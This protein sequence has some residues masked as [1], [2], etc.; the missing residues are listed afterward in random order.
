MRL[1]KL[2]VLSIAAVTLSGCVQQSLQGNVYTRSEARQVQQLEYATVEQVTP[3]IIEGDK[4]NPVG[5]G[6]GAIVGGLAGSTIGGG[7]G[8]SIATVLGAVAGG[9]A[10]QALQEEA[11]RV[12]GQ[13]IV[14]RM[15]NGKLLSV[16]QEV[17]NN[18]FF[19]IGDK[20][21]VLRSNGTV[22]VSY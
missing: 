3:V 4:N 9:L 18:L 10:G 21:R 6:A 15:E 20:V 17:E 5:V 12:Q 7:K 14:L 1:N 2:L 22:R 11:T 8:S 16:V 13:E 19:R